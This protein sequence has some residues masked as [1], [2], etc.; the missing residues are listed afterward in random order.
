MVE[1]KQVISHYNLIGVAAGIAIG[2]ASK[3]FIFSILKD[4]ATPIVQSIYGLKYIPIDWSGFLQ[5]FFTFIVSLL[6][7]FALLT[8]LLKPIV[9]EDIDTQNKNK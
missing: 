6:I 8:K 5:N 7:V 3:D 2:S 1:L 4:V 9:E